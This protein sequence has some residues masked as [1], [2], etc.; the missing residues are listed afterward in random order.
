MQTKWKV[1]IVGVLL[2]MLL[3][4]FAVAKKYKGTGDAFLGVYTQTVDE[5]IAGIRFFESDNVFEQHA[6][7]AAAGAHQHEDLPGLHVESRQRPGP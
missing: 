4:S 5:D 7:A 3:V 6:L 2:S 1:I